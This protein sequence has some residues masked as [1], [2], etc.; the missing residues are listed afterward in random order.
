MTTHKSIYGVTF[1]VQV[2]ELVP[3]GVAS[4]HGG[5]QRGDCILS[6][7]GHSL[8]GLT[9]AEALAVLKEAGAHVT[10]VTSRVAE[11][12]AGC[13]RIPPHASPELNSSLGAGDK[14]VSSLK[15]HQ[16][17]GDKTRSN[18]RPRK[19]CYDKGH[20]PGIGTSQGSPSQ[21]SQH[22]PSSMDYSRIESWR[23]SLQWS[24]QDK[25]SWMLH[26]P[27][28]SRSPLSPESIR[29]FRT[30]NPQGD[31]LT[32]K[33]PNS[34]LPRKITGSKVGV[35]L[36]ELRK[37][38]GG[39]VGL[40]LEGDESDSAIPITVKVVLKGGAAFKSGRICKGDEVI[41]VNGVSFESLTIWEA[42][43]YMRGLSTGKVSMIMREGRFLN[44]CRRKLF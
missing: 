26:S 23:M 19:S 31:I 6:V 7:N 39:W 33:D 38:H 42:V 35:Y 34:T 24:Q 27:I 12:W 21:V 17:L 16:S 3:G 15:Q 41:E 44:S 25:E 9:T 22:K 5:I 36:V 14:I 43:K 4:Q 11:T 2:K 32:F 8:T 13:L 30:R 10:L 20:K 40:Q 1:I 18:T 37:E 29:K 28:S